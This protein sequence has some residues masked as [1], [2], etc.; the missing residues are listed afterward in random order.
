MSNTPP[1]TKEELD[2]KERCC[3]CGGSLAYGRDRKEDMCECGIMSHLGKVGLK[4]GKLLNPVLV[5]DLFI[6]CG[7]YDYV[8]TKIDKDT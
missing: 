6:D 8:T 1:K 4:R 7:I 2:P 3:R 5:G